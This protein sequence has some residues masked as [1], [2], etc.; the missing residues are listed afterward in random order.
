MVI[1]TDNTHRDSNAVLVDGI[2]SLMNG[3]VVA[4]ALMNVI[5]NTIIKHTLIINFIIRV[6]NNIAGVLIERKIVL[7]IVCWLR[8]INRI[9]ILIVVSVV[10]VVVVVQ[11]L[12]NF[13]F[14]NYFFFLNLFYSNSVFCIYRKIIFEFFICNSTVTQITKNRGDSPQTRQEKSKNRIKGADY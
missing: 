7:S 13:P 11:R 9:K 8:K 14:F 6:L 1:I 2:T 4:R 12:N 5:V 3:I 10:S